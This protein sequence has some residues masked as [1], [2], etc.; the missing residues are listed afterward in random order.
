M[1][2]IPQGVQQLL[3]MEEQ[4]QNCCLLQS[5]PW[6]L[7]MTPLPGQVCYKLQCEVLGQFCLS[8]T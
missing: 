1:W 8:L 4:Q 5:Q 6:L 3:R 2:G 7:Q